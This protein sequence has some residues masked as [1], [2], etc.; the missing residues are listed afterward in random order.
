MSRDNAITTFQ[1]V[2]AA[3]AGTRTEYFQVGD[4]PFIAK[5]VYHM[6]HTAGAD[7]DETCDSDWAYTTDG[8]AFTVIFAGTARTLI[9]DVFCFTGTSAAE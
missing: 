3:A 9:S 6:L 2:P 7:E 5:N 8:S 1:S 4:R